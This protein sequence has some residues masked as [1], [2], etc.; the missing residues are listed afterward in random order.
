MSNEERAASYY[1]DVN[2][3]KAAHQVLV[4]TPS[5]SKEFN[6]EEKEAVD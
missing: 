3:M 5:I 6:D 1:C 2:D 4:R